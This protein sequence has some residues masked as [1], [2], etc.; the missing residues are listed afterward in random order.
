[1]A[2]VLEFLEARVEA[3]EREG[4]PRERILIDPGI[5]FGKRKSDN[6]KLLANLDR[7][8]ATGLPVLL[9]TSR[10]RFMGQVLAI[11]DP[12][13][14]VPATVAT[15]ALGV[16][17]GVKVFRVHDVAANYQALEVAWAILNAVRSGLNR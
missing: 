1:V 17:A 12:A 10:K 11:Q 4:I 7:F 14:L 13:E 8:V 3:A 5:G 6:L 9:G 16:M 2:E 15:T